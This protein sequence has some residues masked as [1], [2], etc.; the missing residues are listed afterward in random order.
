MEDERTRLSTILAA[1]VSTKVEALQERR[2]TGRIVSRTGR[3]YRGVLH[4]WSEMLQ[5]AASPIGFSNLSTK[6]L[7]SGTWQ[8]TVLLDDGSAEHISFGLK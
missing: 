3:V 7:A 4:G 5:Y 1:E 6:E 2:R 8:L